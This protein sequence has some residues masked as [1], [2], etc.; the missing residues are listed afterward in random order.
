MNFVGCPLGQEEPERT[1]KK[2][3]EYQQYKK[4]FNIGML[5]DDPVVEDQRK[6]QDRDTNDRY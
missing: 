1:G 3:M 5:V 6:K 2:E 4:E